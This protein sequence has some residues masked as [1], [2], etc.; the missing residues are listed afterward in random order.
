MRFKRDTEKLLQSYNSKVVWGNADAEVA[1][2][3]SIDFVFST[4]SEEDRANLYA[5]LSE[6]WSSYQSGIPRKLFVATTIRDWQHK[7]V[8]GCAIVQEKKE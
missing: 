6:Q 3:E 8:H 4:A 5:T 1:L 7:R 2:S